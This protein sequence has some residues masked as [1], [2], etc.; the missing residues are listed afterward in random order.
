MHGLAASADR[1]LSKFTVPINRTISDEAGSIWEH[2]E[3]NNKDFYNWGFSAEMA[4]AYPDSTMKYI[5]ELYTVNYP[6]P[7][8]LTLMLPNDH[9][10]RLSLRRKLY[11]RQ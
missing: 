6:L 10:T 4:G 5:G 1:K 3:R 9:G 2:L 8:L 7:V 11:G